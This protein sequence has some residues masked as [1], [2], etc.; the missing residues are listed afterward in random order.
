MTY[1]AE[2]PFDVNN[3][4]YSNGNVDIIS[5]TTH[6]SIYYF[7]M[8]YKFTEI[9]CFSDTPVLILTGMSITYTTRQNIISGCVAK[10][11]SKP[12]PNGTRNVLI[13]IA[14]I[15]VTFHNHHI[16]VNGIS[17]YF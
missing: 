2:S 13:M 6:V 16:G 7:N 12:M 17:T 15:R 4:T 5:N 9:F 11:Y 14:V 8:F 1:L 3:K 10:F